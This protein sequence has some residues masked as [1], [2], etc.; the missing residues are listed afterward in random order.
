MSYNKICPMC[1]AR[2]MDGP[3]TGYADIQ[4]CQPCLKA[5][6]EKDELKAHKTRLR[7]QKESAARLA[8]LMAQRPK[9]APLLS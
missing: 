5:R 1:D 4:T 9:R 2:Y 8:Q 6:A 3:K 7:K